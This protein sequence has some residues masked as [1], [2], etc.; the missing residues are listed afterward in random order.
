MPVFRLTDELIFPHP[1]HAA[2]GGLLAVGGDL[3]PER[4]LL[5][6]AH[7]IFPWYSEYDPILWWSPDPRLVLFPDELKVSASLKRVIRKKV[8]TVTVDRDFR[9]VIRACAVVRTAAGEGTWITDDMLD[10]YV[11]LHELGYAHSVESRFE[12]ELVGGLYG[13]AIGRVFFGESMFTL[14]TDASKVALVHLVELVRDL[15]FHFIDCQTTTEHLKR[16]GAREI[17]R[18][19]FMERLARA[20]REDRRDTA[21]GLFTAETQ[22]RRENSEQ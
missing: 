11:R 20:I 3:S 10:A 17:P 6:Y 2:S 13:V 5:A 19:E 22:R 15:G 16:F 18:E 14:R 7:G 12:G 21:G 8:Y 9:E 1:S 4:L